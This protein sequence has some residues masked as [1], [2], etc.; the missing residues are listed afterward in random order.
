MQMERPNH[1]D[2][3]A[4]ADLDRL[5]RAYRQACPDPEAGA[6]F[7]PQLWAKIEAR[8][9]S[10]NWFSRMARTLV[11]AALAA[12]VILGLMMFGTSQ[13]GQGFD[14]TYIDA[15]MADHASGLE[16]LNLDRISELEQQ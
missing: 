4:S 13:S 9:N 12:S 10:T 2:A 7:M 14:G 15:L 11:T 8:E 5:L 16:A 1:A 3:T 6:N